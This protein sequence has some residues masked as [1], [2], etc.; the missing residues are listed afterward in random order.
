[1]SQKGL[2][3]CSFTSTPDNTLLSLTYTDATGSNQTCTSACPLSTDPKLGIQDFVF[4]DGAREMTGF[5]IDLKEWIGAGAG[6]SSVQLLSDGES[7][8]TVGN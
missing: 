2:A 7:W 6:L 8:E 3:Y 5:V 4:T 1:V